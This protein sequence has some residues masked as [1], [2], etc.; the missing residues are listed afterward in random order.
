MATIHIL[1][2]CSFIS[3]AMGLGSQ[4]YEECLYR[5]G[6][7]FSDNIVLSGKAISV[8]PVIVFPTWAYTWKTF[9]GSDGLK[10]SCCNFSQR[11][12]I[13][14]PFQGKSF[15][16]PNMILRFSYNIE[17]RASLV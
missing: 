13:L 17:L 3:L 6:C 1:V 5:L 11:T 8:L 2:I 16:Y 9:C 14:K 7:E 15:L 10:D 12:I 4:I